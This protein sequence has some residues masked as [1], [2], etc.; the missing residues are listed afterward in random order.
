MKCKYCGLPRR[1]HAPG[2]LPRT[3]PE[4]TPLR[5]KVRG[6]IELHRDAGGV[7]HIRRTTKRVPLFNLLVA[8][9]VGTAMAF[10]L[11]LLLR[12]I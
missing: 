7:I 11:S 2:C 8:I 4:V 12:W 5:Y 6:G 9:L 3:P 1:E 10:G